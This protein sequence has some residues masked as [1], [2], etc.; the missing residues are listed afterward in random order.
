M[1]PA[2]ADGEEIRATRDLVL[3]RQS[4]YRRAM[5]PLGPFEVYVLDKFEALLRPEEV[6]DTRLYADTPEI[7]A[8]LSTFQL[9]MLRMRP[10]SEWDQ[11]PDDVGSLR[12]RSSN[13]MFHVVASEEE[14]KGVLNNGD[15]DLQLVHY[16]YPGYEHFDMVCLAGGATRFEGAKSSSIRK[17]IHESSLLI[18]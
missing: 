8:F 10:A 16:Q 1:E 13:S 6:L 2:I 18:A 9:S 5:P 7:E 17:A 11:R 14:L 4:V 3:S 15:A 12:G